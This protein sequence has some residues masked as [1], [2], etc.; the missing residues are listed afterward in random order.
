MNIVCN[1]CF[2]TNRIPDDKDHT[3]AKCGKCQQPIYAK[4]PVNLSDNVFYPFI[5]RN[6]LPVVVDFWASWCG[7]CQQM[8]PVFT[9]VATETPQILF[10]KVNTEQAQQISADAGIR[11]IPT[12]IFFHQ[13]QEIDRVSGV[14]NAVQMKQWIIGCVQKLK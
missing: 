11:S 14:L 2:T 3:Q 8:A 13:G 9:Q 7:P 5:E 6:H 10:A 4:Q 12:L 1:H